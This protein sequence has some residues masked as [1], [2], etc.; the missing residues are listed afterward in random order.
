MATFISSFTP[1]RGKKFIVQDHETALLFTNGRF[2]RAL[3]A[4]PHRFWTLGHVVKRFDERQ[5]QLLV[6]GQD[7]LT[8]DQVALKIS[9]LLMFRLEDALKLHNSAEEPLTLLYSH[10]QLALRQ[11]VASASAEVFL[12]AK[13]GQGTQLSALLAP[14]VEELGL[15]LVHADIRDVMLP[16]DLKRSFMSALQQRQEAQAKLEKARSETAALR[17]LANAAQL[18]RDN[19]EL[20]SLRYLQTLQEVGTTMG[21]TLVLGLTDAGKLG[22][23]I[24]K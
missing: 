1:I 16:S 23:S 3:E 14:K 15:H 9:L 21:N 8:S 12:E 22:I 24:N 20:L 11:V 2:S 17:S 4:G 7:L 19:P 5:Q 10:A 18:M 6:Q 13:S